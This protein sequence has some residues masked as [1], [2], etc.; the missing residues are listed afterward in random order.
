MITPV[1]IT[2]V[3]QL[4]NWSFT[5]KN[6]NIANKNVSV[7]LTIPSDFIVSDI[8]QPIVSKGVVSNNT[9]TI[10]SG[11][12]TLAPQE[13][14]TYSCNFI[15][16]EATE[17]INHAYNFVGVVSGLLNSNP[18]NNTITNTVTYNEFEGCETP[19]GS[20]TAIVSA[21]VEIQLSNYVVPCTTGTPKYVVV[22]ETIEDV[23]TPVITNGT[24]YNWNETTGRVLLQHKNPKL[25]ITFK[26]SMKCVVANED[27]DVSCEQTATVAPLI[28]D[29][30]T[31]NHLIRQ[32]AASSLSPQDKAILAAHPDHAE[33]NI[34]DYCWITLRNADGILT[35]GVPVDCNERQDTRHF[36]FCSAVAC[37]NIVNNCPTCDV[38]ELPADIQLLL[39]DIITDEKYEESLGD[40]ITVNHPNAASHYVYKTLGWTRLDC[41]CI[42]KISSDAGNVLILGDDDAPMLD[43]AAISSQFLVSATDTETNYIAAKLT[44]DYNIT[45]TKEVNSGVETLKFKHNEVKSVEHNTAGVGSPNII[46]ASEN[47]K[48]FT[49]KGTTVQN[50]HTLPAASPGLTFEYAV[51]DTDGITITANTDDVIVHGATT[52]TPAGTISSTTVGSTLR[53]VAIDTISWYVMSFTGTWTTA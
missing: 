51:V 37:A 11:N 25:P 30:S 22:T 26:W 21:A 15:L 27:I 42:K 36:E 28:T 12:N 48:I 47:G 34:D 4:V 16:N 9:W 19:L 18:N 45:I 41:G 7:A 38:N 44:A 20:T 2:K 17:G 35:S 31:I 23:V 52:S 53:L 32:V 13:E 1:L 46:A 8:S 43:P 24:I 5:V 39:A 49:N 33:I 6:G 14:V 40:T 10:V 29:L 50:Y 3:G